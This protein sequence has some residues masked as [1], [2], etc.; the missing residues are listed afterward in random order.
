MAI[1]LKKHIDTPIILVGGH[2][3]IEMMNELIEKTHIDALSLSRPLISEPDLPNRWQ[4]GDIRPSRCI[5]C[6]KCYIPL[7]GKCIMDL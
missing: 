4:N 1:E 6:N 3:S 7:G 5:S 2:R